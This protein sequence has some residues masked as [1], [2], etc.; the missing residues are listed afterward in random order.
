VGNSLCSLG[1]ESVVA[2]LS[3]TGHGAAGIAEG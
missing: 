1:Y 3:V 2:A